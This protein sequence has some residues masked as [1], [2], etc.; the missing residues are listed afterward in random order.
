MKAGQTKAYMCDCICVFIHVHILYEE[1]R[2]VSTCEIFM[3]LCILAYATDLCV[4]VMVVFLACFENGKMS[5]KNTEYL[6][7]KNPPRFGTQD[8]HS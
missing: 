7:L 5:H 8:L 3:F 6:I 1:V 4:G 2:C